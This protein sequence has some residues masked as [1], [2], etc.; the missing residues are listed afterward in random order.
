MK[1]T[2]FKKECK[3]EDCGGVQDHQRFEHQDSIQE[4]CTACGFISSVERKDMQIGDLN[5]GKD[6]ILLHFRKNGDKYICQVLNLKTKNIRREVY[7]RVWVMPEKLEIRPELNDEIKVIFAEMKE[8]EEREN[9]FHRFLMTKSR[10][11]TMKERE[12]RE[13]EFQRICL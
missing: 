11:F 8:R 13:N 6:D 5:M 7:E 2:E 4:S 12:E 9:E 10:L 1:I 3:I